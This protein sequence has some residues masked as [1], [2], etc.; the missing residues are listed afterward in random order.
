MPRR[1]TLWLIPFFLLL[2]N[3]EEAVAFRR[4]LPSL[5][6]R[7]PPAV[8]PF[9]RVGYPQ[10]LVALALATLIPFLVVA[11]AARRPE[12]PARLW[13][14]LVLQAVVLL[15]VFSHLAAATFLMHGYSPGLAT[16]VGVN[17]PFSAYLL[18]RAARERWVS[19]R[20]L[21]W[22][23]PAALVIHGPLL[24]GLILLSGDLAGS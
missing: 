5:P 18:R 12:R 21:L 6:G 2:H 22:C 17:L 23:V 9:A 1:A 19:R 11:W 4:F 14:A 7:L 24:L 10:M 16:A 3:A 15:N 20:A 13:L 8:A